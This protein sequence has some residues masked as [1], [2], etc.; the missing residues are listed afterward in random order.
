MQAPIGRS[1][2]LASNLSPL[3]LFLPTPPPLKHNQS[4]S[5]WSLF[6]YTLATKF[7]SG[8]A[9]CAWLEKGEEGREGRV[10]IL[11]VRAWRG[12]GMTN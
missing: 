12:G 3:S 11:E 10:E 9:R 2:Q 1:I 6:N 7:R 8:S 4:I 5:F